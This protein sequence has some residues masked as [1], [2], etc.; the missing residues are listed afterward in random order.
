M[1]AVLNNT[2]THISE[3]TNQLNFKLPRI[4]KTFM[5]KKTTAVDNEIA[6]FVT[7]RRAVDK[8]FLKAR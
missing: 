2:H 1:Y 5:K 7:T 4:F 8:N 3:E 6:H